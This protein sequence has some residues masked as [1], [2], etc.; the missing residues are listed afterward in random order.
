MGEASRGTQE[1]GWNE[2]ELLR[3]GAAGGWPALP[4]EALADDVL[5]AA[6]VDEIEAESAPAGML[7]ALGAVFVH[8]PQ[9]LLRLAQVRPG[10][11]AAEQLGHEAAGMV[12]DLV[13]LANH[14]L[15]IAH[16]VGRELLRIVLVVGAA[17]A[18]LQACIG[19]DELASVVG[20]HDL[21]VGPHPELT[22]DVLGG[23]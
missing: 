15:G 10:E 18:G 19:A 21:A 5:D 22:A 7:D 4:L 2:S 12:A 20:A 9:E 6:D 23:Q 11:G 17:P 14:A 8:Q 1:A 3:L 16:G 13:G